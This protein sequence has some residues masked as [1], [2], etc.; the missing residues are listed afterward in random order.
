MIFCIIKMKT[1]FSTYLCREKHYDMQVSVEKGTITSVN[2]A[3]ALHT[4]VWQIVG[5]AISSGFYNLYR[6]CK[7]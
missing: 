5:I 7:S 6:D 1:T 4:D 2:K 3:Y